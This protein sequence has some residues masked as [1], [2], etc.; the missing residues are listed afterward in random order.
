MY[1]YHGWLSTFETIDANQLQ[2]ELKDINGDY[3][4]SAQYVNGKL[5]ISFSGSPNR[6]LGLVKKLVTFL[7]N[8]S[9]KLSGCIY[10]NDPN[11]ERYNKFDVLKI[12]HDKVKEIPDNNFTDEETKLLFE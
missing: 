4:V 5:H 10:I 1:E 9:L 2:N 7:C 6:H 8:K 11:S 3:P 12:V